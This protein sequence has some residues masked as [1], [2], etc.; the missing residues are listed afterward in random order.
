MGATDCDDDDPR[1]H[2]HASST[3]ATDSTVQLE[4]AVIVIDLLLQ[5]L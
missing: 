5:A 4:R 1:R 3:A 2:P